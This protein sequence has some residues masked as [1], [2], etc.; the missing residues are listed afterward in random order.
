MTDHKI[1]KDYYS[2]K[3]NE[4]KFKKEKDKI[5]EYNKSYSIRDNDNKKILI[6]L[7]NVL[8]P[9]GVENYKLSKILNINIDVETNK[10][11]IIYYNMID[12]LENELKNN[13]I[14][15]SFEDKKYVSCLKK[16]S[17]GYT[18]R[19]HI[20]T[21]PDVYIMLGK[22]KNTLSF[23]ELKKSTS[24]IDVELSLVWLFDDK[25]GI[26]WT[27]QNIEVTDFA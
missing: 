21:K 18:M 14:D 24:N 5:G 22:Y 15:L 26:V 10:D 13:F 17:N 19:T 4:L 20:Y 6:H 9:Y 25:Y 2:F 1:I 12:E 11:H 7:K 23:S 16:I 3:F 8:I 27:V